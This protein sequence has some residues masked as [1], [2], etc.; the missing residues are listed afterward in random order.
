MS[1]NDGWKILIK[2]NAKRLTI[3]L[4]YIP[5]RSI[6]RVCCYWLVCKSTAVLNFEWKARPFESQISCTIRWKTLA[7]LELKW[8]A[9]KKIWP[10]NL[11]YKLD[12]LSKTIVLD[13]LKQASPKT[14]L[15][16]DGNLDKKCH[17]KIPQTENKVI[18]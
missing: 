5:I 3:Q 1:Q 4:D 8:L 17:E 13:L 11:K 18:S 12:H 2:T 10:Y 16:G 15:N 14:A 7:D 9:I 6:N